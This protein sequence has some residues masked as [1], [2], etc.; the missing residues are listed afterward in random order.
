MGQLDFLG[1]KIAIE[2]DSLRVLKGA[3]VVIIGA[4]THGVYFLQCV[5]V[6]GEIC[7]GVRVLVAWMR[8]RWHLRLDHVSKRSLDILRKTEMIDREFQQARVLREMCIG[9]AN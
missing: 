1:F 4:R 5:T 8:L 2:S 3:L 6:E 9:K 7:V